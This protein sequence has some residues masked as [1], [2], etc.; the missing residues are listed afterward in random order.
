M[1]DRTY[2]R[3][4]ADAL[5]NTLKAVPV[6]KDGLPARTL[7]VDQINEINGTADPKPKHK[8]PANATVVVF[9]K[10]HLHDGTL[11]F[12]KDSH[13]AEVTL[14]ELAE[15]LMMAGTFDAFMAAVEEAKADID[16]FRD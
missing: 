15:S 13:R 9:D 10:V 16:A 4:E 7:T 14:E 11:Y 5:S 8:T 2:N 12:K 6:G 3:A 1:T